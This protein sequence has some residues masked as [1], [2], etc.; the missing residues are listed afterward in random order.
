MDALEKPENLFEESTSQANR[1]PDYNPR[2]TSTP[3]AISLERT[4]PIDN[5]SCC[6]VRISR[7]L[8]QG[9]GNET[10]V[11]LSLFPD[12]SFFVSSVVGG[13]NRPM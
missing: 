11:L 4:I 1:I 12:T 5:V 8:K 2:V 13:R 3:G 9:A 10:T 7:L 6:V